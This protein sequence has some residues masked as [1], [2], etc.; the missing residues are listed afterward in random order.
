[1][2]YLVTGGTGFIGSHVVKELI[3][4]GHRVVT[5]DSL[6][7]GN[8]IEFVLEPEE[9]KQ[10]QM[11]RGDITDLAFLIKTAKVH[12]V[13]SIIHL[14][15][16]MGLVDE[17]PSLALSVNCQGS[18]NVF[19]TAYLL[20]LKKVVWASSNGVFGSPDQYPYEYLPNDAPHY[21]PSIYGACK[22]FIER[23][24]N[25]YF[26]K[27]NVDSNAPR[28]VMIYGPG[29]MRGAGMF[30][31]EMINKPALGLSATVPYKDE[32]QNFM[33]VKDAARCIVMLCNAER[34]ETRAYNVSGDILK[35]GE[36][37]EIVKRILLE[38]KI[39]LEGGKFTVEL[40]WKYDVSKIEKEVGFHP[41]Y[42]VERGIRESINF[43]RKKHNLSPV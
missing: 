21:P 14:A 30:M 32:L 7:D 2:N 18:I 39:S 43:I 3:S 24:S 28:F 12:K 15:Y 40:A 38:A 41:E 9:I 36:F 4:H 13:E 42:D 11:V 8:S 6:V 37:A 17:N 26:E 10:V 1:M 22:S 31:A 34:T 20:G 5:Y 19:E 23:I 16:I 33:H 29:R 35:V 27:K 25:Y